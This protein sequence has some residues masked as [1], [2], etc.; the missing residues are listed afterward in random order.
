MFIAE[1]LSSNPM[2]Q[3][4]SD[5]KLWYATAESTYGNSELAKEAIEESANVN[6]YKVKGLS[7][8]LI[9]LWE[10]LKNGKHFGVKFL[11]EHGANSNYTDWKGMSL[12]MY[13]AGAQLPGVNYDDAVDSDFCRL[14][15]KYGADVNQKSSISG[16]TALDYALRD[17]SHHEIIDVLLENGAKVTPETLG[18]LESKIKEIHDYPEIY[19][20]ILKIAENQGL[21]SKI[22]PA[23]EAA[24]LENFDEANKLIKSNNF[25]K[26]ELKA[27][28]IYAILG[29]NLDT[30]KL[31]VQKGFDLSS[32]LYQSNENRML[33]E[34]TPLAL[35]SKVG[36][37][38]ILKYLIEEKKID[39]NTYKRNGDKLYRSYA[40]YYAV[41]NGHLECAKYLISKGAD[42]YDKPD[43]LHNSLLAALRSN[44]K[45]LVK[46]ILDSGYSIEDINKYISVNSINV[47]SDNLDTLEYFVSRSYKDAPSVYTRILDSICGDSQ[48][49]NKLDIVK[50]LVEHGANVNGNYDSY[51]TLTS[52]CKCGNVDVVDYLI[53]KG[54]NINPEKYTSPLSFSI[55]S[56]NFE[57]IKLLI[58]N[59]AKIS[60]RDITDAENQGCKRI[61]EYLKAHKS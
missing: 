12:L 10:A 60:D 43:S 31:V 40:L 11:L 22:N 9:P 42:L 29:N 19:K 27:L 53:S 30:L 8:N 18:I 56:G 59:G 55:D 17:E 13:C 50:W 54:V 15:I 6:V 20:K 41:E 23:V 14:L 28:A 61:L 21:K 16:L 3:N 4:E 45:E 48:I 49:K 33:R 34:V 47:T 57:I 7:K 58:E 39:V 25:G 1:L 2:F 35:A 37:I 24:M 52:C 32:W 38:D 5:K 51:F 46:L 36:N 26:D 44:S